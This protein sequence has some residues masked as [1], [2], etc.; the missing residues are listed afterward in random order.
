MKIIFHMILTY[1]IYITFSCSSW[2]NVEFY[3][4]LTILLICDNFVQ[5]YYITP[6]SSIL[7]CWKI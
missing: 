1:F 4:Y 2:S 5:F 6:Q 7:Q 3:G